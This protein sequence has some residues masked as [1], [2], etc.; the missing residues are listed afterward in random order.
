MTVAPRLLLVG[1]GGHCRSVLDVLE[2]TPVRVAG[3]V[4]NNSELREVLGVSV[5]GKD[6]RK[7]GRSFGGKRDGKRF[8]KGDGNGRIDMS[9]GTAAGKDKIHVFA[10]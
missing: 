10:S 1:G 5:L 3:I 8:E 7:G 2:T 4:D 9:G 6:D